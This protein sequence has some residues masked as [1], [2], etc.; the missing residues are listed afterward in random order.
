MASAL[1]PATSRRCADL[2]EVFFAPVAQPHAQ[3]LRDLGAFCLGQR[4][5]EYQRLCALATAGISRCSQRV[6][7]SMP[8]MTW[9]QPDNNSLPTRTYQGLIVAAFPNGIEIG[10]S[11]NFVQ[12]FLP[13]VFVL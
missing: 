11:L 2:A 10:I 4:F 6:A 7:R 5:V 9:L 3:H 13:L 12:V 8:P 1:F